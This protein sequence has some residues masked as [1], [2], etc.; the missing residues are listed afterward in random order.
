MKKLLLMC[1][2]AF[3]VFA[4]ADVEIG[5][6]AISWGNPPLESA[7][8]VADGKSFYT[9]QGQDLIHWNL[10]PLKK[11]EAW[12]VP[13]KTIV[14]KSPSNR[15]HNIY[16]LKDY[17]KV[18]ITSIKELMIYNLQTRKVEKKLEYSS[19]LTVKD[20]D[21]L[22][23]THLTPY[24]DDPFT[25]SVDLEVWQLPELKR[26]RSVNLTELTDRNG[27]RKMMYRGNLLAGRDVIFYFGSYDLLRMI[28]MDKKSFKIKEAETG[29]RKV[30]VTSNGYVDIGPYIYRLSDGKQ[31]MKIDLNN[32]KKAYRFA[33]EHHQT[34]I[35]EFHADF[36]PK[37]ASVVGNLCLKTRRGAYAPY[38]FINIKEGEDK[39][40]IKILS[41]DQGEAVIST[42]RKNYFE[43]SSRSSQLLKM[44]MKDG[45][46]VPMNDATFKK[47]NTSFNLGTD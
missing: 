7:V 25:Y 38:F 3:S 33:D 41:Q 44:R 23:L 8:L 28:I 45:E 37:R 43:T 39:S 11:L 10:S 15:F 18:L 13:L 26:I 30:E 22:Y 6:P 2:L 21:T 27:Y 29:F 12:K 1:L 5:V 47:Y 42:Y 17:S 40:V 31:I 19:Y 32:G 14:D 20:G 35:D 24:K 36:R 34:V 4:F 16:L 9:L 46:I